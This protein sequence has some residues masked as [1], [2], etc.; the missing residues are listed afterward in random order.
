MKDNI[1]LG[2][3]IHS[4][5]VLHR[6]DPR[7]KLLSVLTFTFCCLSLHN[8]G[9]YAVATVFAGSQ[10]LLSRVPVRMFLRGLQ[11]VV[12]ILSFTFVYHLFHTPG[13]P[14]WPGSAVKVTGAGIENGIFVVWRILLLVS[15]ASLLTLTTKP[16]DL[17]K[18]LEKLFKPLSRWGVPVEAIALM[19]V[20]AVRFIPTIVQELDRIMLAQRARGYEIMAVK[21]YK[22]I[23]AYLTLVVPLLLSTVQRAEQLAMTIDARAYGTGK[24][25]TSYRELNLSRMDYTAGGVT[26]AYV[27]LLLYL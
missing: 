12:L 9:G 10:L 14:L 26:L 11:P 16:L 21:G 5:S 4:G 18:G 24:G 19:L 23:L 27:L 25:R 22:R 2:Q 15:L 3:Y 8:V 6:L 20:L 7:T 17:A 1:L 13:T